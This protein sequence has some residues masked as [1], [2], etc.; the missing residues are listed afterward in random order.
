MSRTIRSCALSV[1]VLWA[2]PLLAQAPAADSPQAPPAAS[3]TS[4]VSVERTSEPATLT[5]FNRP[6]VT[7]R[8]RVLGRLPAERA[9][10][11]RRLLEEEV[12]GDPVGTVTSLPIAGGA[13]INIGSRTMFGLAEADV[14]ELSGETF[15][16]VTRQTVA[17]LQ[18]ALNEAREAHAPRVLLRSLAISTVVFLLALLILWGLA[19]ARGTIERKF[20]SVTEHKV[21]KTGFARLDALRASRILDIQRYV[22]SALILAAGAVVVYGATTFILRQF[23]YT[24]PWGESMSGFLLATV[25]NLALSVVHALPGLF[26]VAL[27]FTIV[28]FVVR[29]IKLWFDAV[30][31]GHAKARWVY[32]D[33]AQPTRRIV[34]TLLWLFAIIVAYP[35][36]PGSNTEAFKGV[37]VFL[38]LMVTFGSSGL[39]NQIMSGFMVTYSRALRV[40]DFVKTGDVEGTVLHVGM[41][42]TKIKT[43]K[44]EEVT[45][46]N[47]VLVAQTTTDYSRYSETEGVFTPT[48][49]TIG[50]DAPWRQ[51]HSLLLMAAERTSG[52]RRVPEPLVLQASLEDFYVKYTL[53]VCLERQESRPFV[54]DALHQN[55]Q[56]AFNEYGVQIMSPNYVLDPA[57]PKVVPKTQWFAAPAKPTRADES[58]V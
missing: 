50:Y 47:A 29:V 25:E 48:S 38:G 42:S 26:T 46:P 3:L 40:S 41:L 34:T 11:A 57:A 12:E 31:R 10:G 2:T 43:L 28:R 56:D 1:A 14:D 8:A 22:A 13:L 20:V 17:R 52:L 4:A 51:V 37:S 5:F 49:V 58:P 39:V 15:D 33:T 23:P 6:I 35:Y 19:R 21:T 24:R 55:I 30:E 27:I 7:F 44:N 9:A 18:Q 53:L 32:P 54:L 45:V 16:G 36:M